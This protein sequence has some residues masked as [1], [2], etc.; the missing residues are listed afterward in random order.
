MAGYA[1]CA[2]VLDAA[3]EPLSVREALALISQTL[4][5][6]LAEQEGDFVAD[7]R[8]ALAW[9]EQHGFTDGDYGNAE[10]PSKAKNRSVGGM[11]NA[12]ILV[13]Q[14]EAVKLL[15][16]RD[17]PKAW[18]PKTYPRPTAWEAVHHL[19]RTLEA[20][21]EEGAAAL[22]SDLGGMAETARELF[23]RLYTVCDLRKRSAE[24]APYN[25]LA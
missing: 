24:A 9:F 11:V 1:H 18:D 20:A 8:W 5:E 23:F 2:P 25:S 12:G 14:G 16:P 19:I 10:T 7:S 17:L 6:L 22:A 13:S 21:G 3:G 15:A 4:N